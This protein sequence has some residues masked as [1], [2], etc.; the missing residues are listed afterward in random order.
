[1]FSK[2]LTWVM[3]ALVVSLWAQTTFPVTTGIIAKDNNGKTY[4]ID[5]LLN[6]GKHIWV[7][8]MRVG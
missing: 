4:D 8:L 5:S 1:M 7:H 2:I 6:S 3:T